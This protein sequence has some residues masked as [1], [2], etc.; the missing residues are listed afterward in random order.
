MASTPNQSNAEI[1]AIKNA[2]LLCKAISPDPSLPLAEISG[3]PGK[4]IFNLDA[5][6]EYVR[7]Y[8]TNASG[9]NTETNEGSNIETYAENLSNKFSVKGNHGVKGLYAVAGSVTSD[10]N[11]SSESAKSVSFAQKRYSSKFGDIHLPGTLLRDNLRALV[12]EDILKYIDSID[13]DAKA[14]NFVLLQGAVYIDTAEFGANLTLSSRSEGT[15]FSSEKDLSTAV[16]TELT[17]LTSSVSTENKLSIGTNYSKH[18]TNLKIEL[19]SYGGDPSCILRGDIEKWSR[20][21]TE[22]PTVTSYRLA[23][24]SNL[25]IANSNAEKYLIKAVKKLC[26]RVKK[27]LKVIEVPPLDGTYCI[28]SVDNGNGLYLNI[29]DG[30]KYN[31]GRIHQWDYPQEWILTEMNSDNDEPI[32]TLKSKNSNLYLNIDIGQKYNY[33]KIHQWDYPQKWKLEKKG[34][35]SDGSQIVAIRSVESFLHMNVDI[36]QKYNGGKIHQWGYPQEWK[37]VKKG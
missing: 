6:K 4:R 11:C 17:I 35:A 12:R 7:E 34:T 22:N 21:I 29:D 1:V 8:F 13:N 28:Q 15:S 18:T 14:D 37:L 10:F 16:Q 19:T 33:G 26:D 24:V 5:M 9:T 20:S 23:P 36:G 2:S 25:A 3:F 27:S 30:Q 31:G 32:I